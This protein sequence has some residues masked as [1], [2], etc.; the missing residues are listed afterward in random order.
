M[1]LPLE[2]DYTHLGKLCDSKNTTFSERCVT[3]QPRVTSYTTTRLSQKRSF[4]YDLI[5]DYEGLQKRFF[6]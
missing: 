3:K 2:K 5:N 4:S 1:F 6:S